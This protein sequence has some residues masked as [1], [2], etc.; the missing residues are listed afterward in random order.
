VRSLPSLNALRVF[1]AA[2]RHGSFKLAAAELSVTQGAVS[3]QIHSLEERLGLQL[4]ERTPRRVVLTW[5]G[6]RYADSLKSIFDALSEATEAILAPTRERLMIGVLP[7]FA[8]R[9]LIPRLHAFQKANPDLD[10]DLRISL[11]TFDFAAD[12]IDMAI[13]HGRPPWRAAHSHLLFSQELTPVC[14]PLLSE[15][16]DPIRV[17][18]DL[19]RH[20]L[21]HVTREMDEWPEWLNAAGVDDIDGT[22]G[23]KFEATK[24]ALDAAAAGLGVAMVRDPFF[25]EETKSGQLVTPF[26]LRIR[27]KSAYYLVYPDDIADRAKVQ[28]FRDWL[29]D[30]VSTDPVTARAPEHAAGAHA[31]R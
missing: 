6:R 24:M 21:L 3:Q 17:P 10:V 11:K 15:G 13:C 9:W 7:T 8:T 22:Q 1:E 25:T 16:P 5:A 14:S 30:E 23:L 31:Q 20:T 19:R 26:R 2:A 27:S 29:L 4:F 18:S 12:A 28:A